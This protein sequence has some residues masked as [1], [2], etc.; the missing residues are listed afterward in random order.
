MGRGLK[1]SWIL[2]A[3][4]LIAFAAA[5]LGA[6]PAAAGIQ[7]LLLIAFVATHASLGY[8]WRGFA[9]FFAIALPVAFALEASSIHTGFP[10]GFYEHGDSFGP[11]LLGVPAPVALGYVFLGYL[12][13]SVARVLVRAAPERI[14]RAELW[15]TPLAGT[16]ILAG[17]D[18]AYDP[19]GS[20]V[21]GLWTYR[22]PSG[23]F[24][25]PLT[26]FLG[27]LLTGWVILQ[28]FALIE[29]RF[30]ARPATASKGYWLQPCLI[31]TITALQYP[32]MF[33]RAAEGTVTRGGR[34]FVI[35]DVYE[36]SVIVAL[37][38]MVFVALAAIGRLAGRSP[39]ES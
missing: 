30:P 29:R 31:W 5:Q 15:T 4:W 24:G 32:V 14:G 23:Y 20:T 21:L 6:G 3:L 22:F 27:W 36:A 33:A 37:L 38:T 10:F 19:I 1:A 8:G 13:W 25:V 26:N 16:F 17:Y 9:A 11:K 18:L 28:L 12:A 34:T 35:A 7:P 2:W 39:A